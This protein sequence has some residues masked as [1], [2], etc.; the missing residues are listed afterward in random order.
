MIVG[1]DGSR[2]FTP[3]RTGTENYS[4]Q[5]LKHLAAIDK[6][7][8][9]LVFLRPG[10][11]VDGEWPDNFEFKFTNFKRLWTQVGLCL[12]TFINPID[13]LFTPAHTLPLIRKPGLKTVMTVHDLGAEYLPG[14]H[15]L[16]QRLY[17][18]FI[19]KFQLKGATKL[20][21]VSKATKKDLVAKAGV[22]SS[23][24]EVIY[25]GGPSLE[26]KFSKNDSKKDQLRD[27]L[28][29]FDIEEKNYFL[30]VGTVQPRKNLARLVEAFGQLLVRGPVGLQPQSTVLANAAG[31]HWGAPRAATP[32]NNL[33][34][35]V[36]VGGRGWMSDEIYEL[37]KRLGI[38]KQVVFTGRVEDRELPD[39]YQGAVGL[40]YPSLHEGF[41]L[42]ILEAFANS[43]PVLTSNLSSMPEV[44]GDAAILVDPFDTDSIYSG[45]V[46]L[47]D[48]KQRST[49]VQLGKKRLESFSW[50]KCAK[51]TLMVFKEAYNLSS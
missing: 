22:N 44:A 47:L 32:A 9:Y 50:D 2:A 7:N 49:L 33:L 39:L 6:Q 1:F 12:Q 35:L 26:N 31:A 3:N 4:Y 27:V 38:E 45:M 29:K 34:K 23:K 11:K 28:K 18:G 51:E 20:I 41:G 19:T 37:P 48:T 16:K 36:I 14:M 30:F 10:N 13:V 46:K 25:E 15:Q 42:P 43:C 5:L 24:I 17:L 8:K 40:V 21:A